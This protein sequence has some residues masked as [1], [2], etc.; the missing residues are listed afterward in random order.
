MNKPLISAVCTM[1]LLYFGC[2]QAIINGRELEPKKVERLKPFTIF[3]QTHHSKRTLGS[4]GSTLV[5]DRYLLTASHCIYDKYAIA[6]EDEKGNPKRPKKVFVSKITACDTPSTCSENIRLEKF[7][8]HRI[9]EPPEPYYPRKPFYNDLALIVLERPVVND[10]VKL[11]DPQ[12]I[13]NVKTALTVLGWGLKNSTHPSNSLLKGTVEYRSISMDDLE[14]KDLGPE[15]LKRLQNA[16]FIL[17]G[18]LSGQIPCDGDS[19]GPVLLREHGSAWQT[20]VISS[21][22]PELLS[23]E[24]QYQENRKIKCDPT[25]SFSTATNLQYAVYR[26]WIE[27]Y[28][29]P[30]SPHHGLPP[31]F[32]IC[33]KDITDYS[34][35][36]Y[37]PET[38]LRARPLFH[39][40]QE[41]DTIPIE[42]NQVRCF[43]SGDF[44]YQPSGQWLISVISD[45]GQLGE[46]RAVLPT[47]N[48]RTM[49]F[50]LDHTE[51]KG[52]HKI[53]TD[54]QWGKKTFGCGYA[55]LSDY[56][57]I[58]NATL[59]VRYQIKQLKR[60]DATWDYEGEWTY[61]LSTLKRN[62]D[63]PY[64]QA[65]TEFKLSDQYPFY[66]LGSLRYSMDVKQP[67]K[68][69][70]EL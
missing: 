36:V 18:K 56:V 24:E 42:Q 45:L 55:L 62:D 53:D 59:L 14:R 41:V 11:I 13:L 25:N 58:K 44:S 19:G 3:M 7:K 34:R 61:R 43:T 28:I 64:Q 8:V 66:P 10:P 35:L 68:G 5:G 67:A 65:M 27:S 40:D 50:P 32:R 54:S 52:V 23:L 2:C 37:T 29:G 6:S 49:I 57:Q 33:V 16:K 20:G 60:I 21:T 31:V 48:C 38:V 46:P 26:D 22:G 47:Q 39:S 69:H 12:E 9:V 4:C 1:T 30:Y 70:D 15:Y 63:D 17:N 51:T